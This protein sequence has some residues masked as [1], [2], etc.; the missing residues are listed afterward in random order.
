VRIE[1]SDGAGPPV[2]LLH[3][4]GGSPADWAG[5]AARLR[6]AGRAVALLHDPEEERPPREAATELAAL[7][8]APAHLVGHGRGA[9]VASWIAV[10]EPRLARS[11][12]V[13]ASPPEGSEAF[14]A[15]FRERGARHLAELPDDAWPGLALRR[16]R[17]PALVVE[18]EDD[19][20]YSPTHTLFWRAYL[21]YASFERVPGNHAFFRESP[22]REAWLADRLLS[23]FAEAERRGG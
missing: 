20:L 16:Y 2:A 18:A 6:E 4:A 15:Y 10:E 12:A 13:V 5:V 7:L 22:A 3:G 21:P 19:P 8:P 1:A 9:T 14:R 23:F 11:L 17:G